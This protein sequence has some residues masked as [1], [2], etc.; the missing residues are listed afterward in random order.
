MKVYSRPEVLEDHIAPAFVGVVT[1]PMNLPPA[2]VNPSISNID[3]SVITLGEASLHLPEP[4]APTLAD[5]F[6]EF[7]IR[8]V[9]IQ[10][11]GSLVNSPA[12]DFNDTLF[13]SLAINTQIEGAL[14]TTTTGSL[15]A[16]D[17]RVS[18]SL[19][20]AIESVV[21]A[22]RSAELVGLSSDQFERLPGSAFLTSL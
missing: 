13:Q 12:I 17:L 15:L 5:H 7:H 18:D 19:I 9:A 3:I 1:P 16:E 10:L 6:P 21:G 11:N 2:V 20:G 14:P 22:D 4:I 8:T